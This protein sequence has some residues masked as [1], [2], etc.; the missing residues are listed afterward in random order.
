MQEVSKIVKSDNASEKWLNTNNAVKKLD[1]S[2]ATLY[3]LVSAGEIRSKEEKRE[4]RKPERLFAEVDIEHVL[5]SNVRVTPARHLALAS[6][7][8]QL[9]ARSLPAAGRP[10]LRIDEAAQEFGLPASYITELCRDG[11]I[12]AIRRGAWFLSRKS[13]ERFIENDFGSIRAL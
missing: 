2:K 10:V 9:P 3:R 12:A 1:K 4:G 5:A 6:A 8:R 7:P 11:K 13:L